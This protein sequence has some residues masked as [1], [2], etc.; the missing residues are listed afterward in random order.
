[1]QKCSRQVGLGGHLSQNARLFEY[2][3]QPEH[4]D[5]KL[6]H[7]V[8]PNHGHSMAMIGHNNHQCVGP[9]GLLFS[10]SNK[11]PQTL[12]GVIMS[13]QKQVFLI[14]AG[15]GGGHRYLKWF[16]AAEGE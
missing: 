13:V 2:A 1:M 11:L 3:T 16:V 5:M 7:F 9:P 14:G 12:V 8:G 6:L 4:R 10:L 15:H